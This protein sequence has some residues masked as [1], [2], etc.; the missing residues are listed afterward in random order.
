MKCN[1]Q[2]FIMP[3][4]IFASNLGKL[5]KQKCLTQLGDFLP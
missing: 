3:L 5:F 2:P 4:E 1:L